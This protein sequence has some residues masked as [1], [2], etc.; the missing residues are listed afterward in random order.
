MKSDKVQSIGSRISYAWHENSLT[1]IIAQHIPQRQRMMLEAWFLGWL[2]VG[3]GASIGFAEASGSDRSFYLIFMAF[4]A[5]FAFRVLK[6]ILWRRVG[7]E[8]I[9]IT[10]EGMTV[11]NAFW[12]WG[13]ARFF[14]KGN[15]QKMEV[16][17]RDPSKFIQNLDQ[18]FW[19]MGGDSLEFGYLRGRFV[20]GK[21]LPEKDALQLAKLIDQGLR[22][23]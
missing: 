10:K 7:R 13:K 23:F 14:I 5:F 20:L 12:D 3:I 18:S 22:K 8:M 17:R 2:L 6:V 11:K 21:Q 9:R 4:W 16:I 19:I 1:V 15:I